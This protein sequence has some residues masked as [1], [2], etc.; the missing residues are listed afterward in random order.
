MDVPF[1]FQM[2][3]KQSMADAKKEAGENDK[4]LRFWQGKHDELKLTDVEYA[5]L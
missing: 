1:F 2:E 5:F 3:L 4:V